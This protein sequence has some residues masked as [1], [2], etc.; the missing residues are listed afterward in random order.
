MPNSSGLDLN[1]Q[2]D[3]ANDCGGNQTPGASL[4]SSLNPT[5]RSRFLRPSGDISPEVTEAR[6]LLHDSVPPSEE[7]Q[8][9]MQLLHRHSRPRPAL[10]GRHEPRGYD[11][12]RGLERRSQDRRPRA[13]NSSN[14]QYL[15]IVVKRCLLDIQM[16]L[17]TPLV[18]HPDLLARMTKCTCSAASSPTLT[19]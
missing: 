19:G 6:L 18:V 7:E 15:Q 4:H 16:A 14:C 1:W 13:P 8:V 3:T 10:H 9:F 5:S 17:P 12:K 2:P 11:R